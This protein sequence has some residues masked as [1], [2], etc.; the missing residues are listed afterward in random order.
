MNG[1]PK[2][3]S[4]LSTVLFGNK[5]ES[6]KVQQKMEKA[7]SSFPVKKTLDSISSQILSI[8]NAYSIDLVLFSDVTGEDFLKVEDFKQSGSLYC[9]YF[10]LRDSRFH[11]VLPSRDVTIS[12]VLGRTGKFKDFNSNRKSKSISTKYDVGTVVRVDN[13]VGFLYNLKV[14]LTE[15]G[16]GRK[17]KRFHKS[18]TATMYQILKGFREF[19][20]C[21]IELFANDK[22][23][24]DVNVDMNDNDKERPAKQGYRYRTDVK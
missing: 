7:F 6:L 13:R 22:R 18:V 8:C 12:L 17:K 24:R 19:D 4:V 16:D 14:E 2:I 21:A 23:K 10:L 11:A 3:S 1:D 5:E 15:M 9:A 20:R